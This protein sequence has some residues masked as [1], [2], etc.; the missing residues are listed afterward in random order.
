MNSRTENR[1]ETQQ[2]QT[3]EEVLNA[4][5]NSVLST[6][7]TQ[8]LL[9]T[10]SSDST[11]QNT[12]EFFKRHARTFLDPKENWQDTKKWVGG[13]VGVG[14]GLLFITIKSVWGL[15]KFTK[16]IIEKKGNITFKEGYEI[17][18]SVFDS[19]KNNK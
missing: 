9:D 1:S 16:K 12:Q 17:G 11:L 18:K 8:E 2:E 13:S 14:G 3:P 6:A 5:A 15:L 19:E 10:N 4:T 7:E